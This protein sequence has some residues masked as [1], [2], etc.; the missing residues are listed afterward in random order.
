MD[1]LVGDAEAVLI[2]GATL[3]GRRRLFHR[4]LHE[5]AARPLVVSTLQPADRVRA[6][7]ERMLREGDAGNGD[8]AGDASD[9]GDPEDR[10]GANDPLVVDCLT[11]ALGRSATDDDATKFA[12]HPSNL[13]SIG[14][15]FTEFVDGCDSGELAVG[16]SS[17]SPLLMYASSTDVYR[18]VHLLVQ[19]SAGAESPVVATIDS[20]AHDELDV[21]RFVPLFDRTIEARR[22][23]DEQ[24]FRVSRPDSTEWWP[25]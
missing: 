12:Q 4:I 19:Q 11:N 14:T 16:L 23:G 25:L 10:D 13:T 3:S 9:A 21:E 17:I 5:W 1:I 20:A 7:H 22:V 18:F 6:T 8:D 24:E 15:K 2:S